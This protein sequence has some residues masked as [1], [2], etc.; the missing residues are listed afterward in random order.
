MSAIWT[1]LF[2]IL[3]LVC[4]VC[5]TAWVRAK[6]REGLERG[7]FDYGAGRLDRATSPTGFKIQVGVHWFVVGTGILMFFA[8]LIGGVVGLIQRLG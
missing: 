6:L 8:G 1:Y 7:Y 5:F 3:W 4:V 2:L